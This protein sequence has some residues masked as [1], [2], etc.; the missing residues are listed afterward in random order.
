MINRLIVTV[1]AALTLLSAFPA[2]VISIVERGIAL[3]FDVLAAP[4]NFRLEGWGGDIIGGEPLAYDGPTMDL[5]H[6]AGT[7]RRAAKRHI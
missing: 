7:H 4:F 3:V 2:A 6:E 5:R 1:C